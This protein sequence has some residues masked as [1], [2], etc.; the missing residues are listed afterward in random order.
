MIDVISS[1]KVGD[2]V[3]L[4]PNSEYA[5]G[6]FINPDHPTN[7]VG[8]IYSMSGDDLIFV[9]WSNGSRQV[10]SSFDL[11]LQSQQLPELPTVGCTCELRKVVNFGCTCEGGQ[12]ELERERK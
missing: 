4:R 7:E 1:L 6:L 9:E 10:Y 3:K 12:A 5:R 11:D 8:E 2:T